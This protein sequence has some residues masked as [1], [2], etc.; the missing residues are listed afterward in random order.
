MP[1]QKLTKRADGRYRCKLGDKYF[2]GH[3]KDEA[4]AARAEYKKLLEAGMK[5]DASRMPYG[6]Y[7]PRWLSIYKADVSDKTYND[8]AQIVGRTM[9]TLGT[10][11][12]AD[13]TPSDIRKTYNIY[14]GKSSST[15]HR[16]RM[17][18]IAIF[19]TAAEEGYCRI[20]PARSKSAKVPKGYTGTHRIITDEE[21]QI[22]S[23]TEHRCRLGAMVMLYAGLR[24]GEMLALNIDKDIDFAAKVIHVRHGIRHQNNQP[25]FADP[26]TS[27][28][29]R[30]VPLMDILANVLSGQ[31][32]Y[33]MH[34]DSKPDQPMSET[35]FRRGWE[36]FNKKMSEAAGHEVSIRCHDLRHS[37]CTFLRD[38]GV[39][40]HLAMK[41][42]GHADEKMILRIYDH[43]TDNRAEKTVE[44]LEK[45]LARGQ[46]GGQK[47][48]EEPQTLIPQA[49]RAL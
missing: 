26:K 36:Y 20:N 17:L 37:Y 6:E 19:D 7:A 22:I 49:I 23:S 18:L 11:A 33:V 15:I 16:V 24:R 10:L 2:Y 32:G 25:V 40:M 48:S 8:Y 45:S 38:E 44:K 42:M 3:T 35:A 28:G 4:L 13:I 1:K 46:N 12:M 30:D 9:E 41:W 14:I 27:A 39:D 5:T 31:H 34:T 29:V 47:E 43:V 21:R